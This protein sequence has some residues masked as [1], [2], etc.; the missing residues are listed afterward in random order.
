VVEIKIKRKK[1]VQETKNISF[2][3]VHKREQNKQKQRKKGEE[4]F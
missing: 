4:R 1:A 2:F 3:F